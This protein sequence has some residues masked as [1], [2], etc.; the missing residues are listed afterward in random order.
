MPSIGAPIYDLDD[1]RDWILDARWLE[2]RPPW[3]YSMPREHSM[4][5]LPVDWSVRNSTSQDLAAER[6]HRNGTALGFEW[7]YVRLECSRLR[8]CYATSGLSRFPVAAVRAGLYP[9][10]TL[11][12]SWLCAIH[13]AALMVGAR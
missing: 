3:R 10:A 13:G 5:S 8:G 4:G 2:N 1:S 6:E 11:G 9:V 12:G 7:L